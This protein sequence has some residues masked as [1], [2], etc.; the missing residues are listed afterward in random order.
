MPVNISAPSVVT[1]PGMVNDLRLVQP[2]S[3]PAAIDSNRLFFANVTSARLVQPANAA[4]PIS[5]TRAGSV[6]VVI[7]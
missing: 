2:L 3:A 5:V 4:V 1:L 7:V 6:T